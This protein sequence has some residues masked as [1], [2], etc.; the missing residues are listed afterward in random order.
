MIIDAGSAWGPG[1]CLE[2]IKSSPDYWDTLD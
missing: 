1:G 2:V